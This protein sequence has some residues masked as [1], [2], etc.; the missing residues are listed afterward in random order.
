MSRRAARHELEAFDK[1]QTGY[2]QQAPKALAQAAYL[3]LGKSFTRI[4]TTAATGGLGPVMRDSKPLF[5]ADHKN[6]G[7]TAFSLTSWEATRIAMARQTELGSGEILGNLTVPRYLMIP[8]HLEN[9]ALV[10]L[11][12]EGEPG[13]P[14]NDI[15]P[16]AVSGANSDARRQAARRMIIVNDFLG[17][18]NNWYA[19]ADPAL[20][21]LIGLGFRYGETPEL[22]SVAD[23][24]SGLMFTNDV[25]PI[26][27]R[28]FY[29]MGPID[30]RGMYA[31]A[32]S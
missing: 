15:N 5:H 16:L 17:T 10:A 22:F 19:M 29:S 18:A 21:N 13:T 30:Y 27:I 24:N 28:F 4:F 3:S 25:M 31:H 14:N 11:A 12:S 20:Y 23:P 6:Y 26:K 9:K 1:D 8:R 2:L 32:V 7:S